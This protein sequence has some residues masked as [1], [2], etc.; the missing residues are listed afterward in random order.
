M[1]VHS[2]LIRW[3]NYHAPS[4]LRSLE[5]QTILFV[6]IDDVC[7]FVLFI[8]VENQLFLMVLVLIYRFGPVFTYLEL[9]DGCI[10]ALLP[11]TVG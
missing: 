3:L 6:A 11:C 5:V 9:E 8:L 2:N 10:E 1:L 4:F 7:N